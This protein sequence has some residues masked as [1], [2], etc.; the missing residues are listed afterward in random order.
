MSATSTMGQRMLRAVDVELTAAAAER[1]VVPVEGFLW[2][3][4]RCAEAMLYALLVEAKVDVTQLAEQ[5]KG[6]DNLAKHAKLQ[7]VIPRAMRDHLDSAQKYGNSATHFQP[8]GLAGEANATIV[9]NALSELARW[10]YARDDRPLPAALHGPIAALIDER[11]RLRSPVELA[12]EQEQRRAHDLAQR[13]DAAANPSV[14]R[15]PPPFTARLAAAGVGL[16][17]LGAALGFGAARITVASPAPS[18]AP[19]PTVVTAPSPPVAPSPA[20]TAVPAPVVEVPPAPVAPMGVTACPSGM[21]R[22][23]AR[24]EPGAFCIDQDAVLEG[25]YRRC[26]AS[27]LCTHPPPAPEN[28]CNWENG[29][30]GLSANC[31][32][33]SLARAYCQHRPEPGDLP[34]RVEW[35]AVAANRV[36]VRLVADTH[37]WSSDPAVGAMRPVR[38]D[39]RGAAFAWSAEPEARGHRNV[40]F[41]C[42]LRA[43]P[44]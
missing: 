27:G 8:D 2:R 12:L 29:L 23:G 39:R 30:N 17:A 34:T 5:G 44:R 32:P 26:V 33:W 7:G 25:A 40:S 3:A 28:G 37:E 18:P 1:W 31:L 11:Q 14:E 38:G 41:R 36:P 19:S 22:V 20:P 13:L 24:G 42:V 15:P 16:V 9:A 35:Q 4:R 10:F 43:E 21:L 6:L